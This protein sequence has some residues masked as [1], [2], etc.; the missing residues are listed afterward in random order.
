MLRTSATQP[1]LGLRGGG[2]SQHT[3]SATLHSGGASRH[4]LGADAARRRPPRAVTTLNA[5]ITTAPF[6][7]T[8]STSLASLS[9]V[10]P[11]Q[12]NAPPIQ[13]KQQHARLYQRKQR[14]GLVGASNRPH[15]QGLQELYAFKSTA[16]PTDRPTHTTKLTV[17]QKR[18]PPP[19]PPGKAKPKAPTRPQSAAPAYYGTRRR[20]RSSR[21]RWSS[22]IGSPGS[23]SRRCSIAGHSGRRARTRVAAVVGGATR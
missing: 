11:Y 16:A 22:T 12:P 3:A 8:A 20:R 21:G 2:A 10:N 19:P 6:D 4:G 7:L 15:V 1:S 14:P 23:R 18:P 9:K 13:Y 5:T 17:V